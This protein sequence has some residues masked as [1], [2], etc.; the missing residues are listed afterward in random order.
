[1]LETSRK[2]REELRGKE[3]FVEDSIL[4]K[5]SGVEAEPLSKKMLLVES[6]ASKFDFRNGWT[7][8]CFE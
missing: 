7:E 6:D 5:E 4:R 3:E 8:A 1:M 2:K